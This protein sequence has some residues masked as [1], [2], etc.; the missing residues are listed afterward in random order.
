MAYLAMLDN[1]SL[2]VAPRTIPAR[3][4]AKSAARIRIRMAAMMLGM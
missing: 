2:P 3:K 4:F 1:I